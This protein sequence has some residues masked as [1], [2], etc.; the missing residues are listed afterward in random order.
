LLAFGLYRWRLGYVR[1]IHTLQQANALTQERAR[2]AKDLHDGLGA[3]LTQLTLLAELAEQEPP[4]IVARRLRGL[5]TTSREAARSLKDF[6]WATH[7]EADTLEG[8]V[9]RLCQ[10]AEEFL[11]AA[12]IRCRLELPDDIPP[13][14]LAVAA[15]NDL[16]LAAKEALNNIVK[17]ARATEV[18]L[19]VRHDDSTLRIT[20]ED[21]GCGFTPTDESAGA[22]PSS[23][24]ANTGHGLGNMAGRVQAAGGRFT[25]ESQP[26][27][28]TTI[29]VEIPI[30]NDMS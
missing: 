18:R 22:R 11:G 10:H 16:F 25:L 13:H 24:A 19:R 15:R 3:N 6:I 5:S 8:L 27:R 7:P 9:T 2:I 26:G 4:E 12:Q 17:H 28:G 21:N 20:I 23:G 14:P 29:T 1:R 30:R